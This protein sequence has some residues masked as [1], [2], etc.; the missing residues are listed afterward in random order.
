[1]GKAVVSKDFIEHS[2]KNVLD[3][4]GLSAK[5]LAVIKQEYLDKIDLQ[6]AAKRQQASSNIANLYDQSKIIIDK[7]KE[8]A[9]NEEISL[10]EKEQPEAT[11]E[12]KQRY[13]D[14]VDQLR[15]ILLSH[16]IALENKGYDKEYIASVET[17]LHSLVDLA[18]T[19]T[20]SAENIKEIFPSYS[21]IQTQV[22]SNVIN[23][24]YIL[25]ENK[26]SQVEAPIN[27]IETV[28]QATVTAQANISSVVAPDMDPDAISADE[29]NLLSDFKL[30]PALKAEGFDENQMK[31][32]KKVIFDFN[33]SLTD[34]LGRKPSFKEMV[35]HFIKFTDKVQTEK[36]FDAYR[37]G[38]EANGFEATNYNEVFNEIFE[39]SRNAA[40]A[41]NAFIESLYSTG[42]SVATTEEEVIQSSEK[43]LQEVQSSQATVTDFTEENVPIKTEN[44]NRIS[45]PALRLGFNAIKYDEVEVLDAQGHGTNTFKR[46]A[47]IT[48]TLNEENPLIDYKELLDPDKNNAG[49]V[50]NV[51][52]APENM[53]PEIMISVGRDAH[54][55][56]ILKSFEQIF[57][58]KLAT[59]P[60]F[61]GSAEFIE[62]V[63]MFAYNS[64]GVAVAYIHEAG[65]YNEWNVKDPTSATG[66]V[67]PRNINLAHKEAIEDAKVKA[68]NFREAVHGGLSQVTIKEKA[69]G[70]FYSI[71][72]RK[73]DAG[74]KIPLYTI[75]EANPQSEFAIQGKQNILEQG[76]DKPFENDKRV[77]IN[78]KEIAEKKQGVTWHLRRIGTNPEGQE[79]WRAF[80]V[81]RYPNE[82]ELETVR[83]A[84][85][86]YSLFD[87]KETLQGAKKAKV[88][89][90]V[91]AKFLPTQYS[92]TED[93]AR[94]I[95]KEIKT[96][97]GYNLMEFED[98]M[99]YFNLF[100]QPRTG[101]TPAEFG[102]TL[103]TGEL[104]GFA[105]HTLRDGL[106]K[107]P[108]I[109]MIKNGEVV[110]TN[111]RYTDYLKGTLKTDVK[112]FNIG[113]SDKPVY[114]TSIQPKIVFEY[115]TGQQ[116]NTP[117]KEIAKA[118]QVAEE[119]KQEV[120]STQSTKELLELANGLI[121]ELGFSFEDVQAMPV[122]M[123]GVDHLKNILNLTPGLSIEQEY[124]LLNFTVQY[125][126]NLIDSKFK[127][128]INKALLMKE[129][130]SSYSDIVG[131]SVDKV[132]AVLT[133][134]ESAP[135][136]EDVAKAIGN[137]KAILRVFNNL[138]K[139][140]NAENIKSTL[141]ISG[142]AYNGQIGIVEKA[143]QEAAELADIQEGEVKL[144]EEEE[145]DLSLSEKSFDDAA[146]MTENFKTKTTFRQKRFMSGVSKVDTKGDAIKGFLGLPQY[147]D[148]NE[149]YD[150]IYSLL[151]SGVYIESDYETMKARLLQM[152]DA[153]PWVKE[154]VD[155][156]DNADTQLRKGLVLNYRKHAI[157]MKFMM[158]DNRGTGS[159]L[160]V[161][162]TNAN[163]I[164]RVIRGEWMNNF[165]TSPLVLVDN[166]QYTI[167]RDVA[168]ALLDEFNSW[169]TEGHLQSD[170]TVRTWLS[171]FGIELTDG[172]WN[173]LKEVGMMNNGKY[174]PYSQLF[175]SPNTP[176]GFLG[177]YLNRV[178]NPNNVDYIKDLRFEENEK[179]HPFKDM[180]GVLKALSKGESR[181]TSKILSKSFRDAQKS[182]TGITNPTYITNRV[183][184]LIRS[185]L[186]EEKEFINQL[187][188]L[189]ISH[190]SVMLELMKE[191]PD[192]AKKLELNHEENLTDYILNI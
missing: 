174:I 169:G 105:Q 53:W 94:E 192:F 166:G 73:D 39:P 62:I 150:A 24:Y 167:N 151:G 142:E 4:Y 152:K 113:T 131:P 108:T 67:N 56:P 60:D 11:E 143:L 25:P 157:S 37:V 2:F 34:E 127:G 148:Y 75:E 118:K 123:N 145:D 30:M 107:N 15:E 188:S 74:N 22:L 71:A 41:A 80:G 153:H 72:N 97:T 182:I 9:Q 12:E 81:V 63:P 191:Y 122:E 187:S 124:Q 85:S 172:Y 160:Q 104:S 27:N 1:M 45:S 23:D 59:N 147:M 168:K 119:V 46:V 137:Y 109:P 31:G 110:S 36:F 93:K 158:Y 3:T 68:T 161:Y 38:W 117:A 186:T 116:E 86:A 112:S 159:R 6:E 5:E 96:L 175:S 139:N 52:M 29:D 82:E 66:I 141:E 7:Q 101:N 163:E 178:A 35:Y 57:N 170:A 149:V 103:Y 134:L 171:N 61:K 135:Q 84:W 155:K 180:Q 177:I 76:V 128:K 54:S 33:S 181:F 102:R 164:T 19:Q 190:K 44:E 69:E 121:N 185:G 79:T 173:E 28:A 26:N 99:A 106:S 176:M 50:L 21:D 156:Y 40:I 49:S 183:D 115:E 43:Q 91:R 20:L 98:A 47:V 17:N 144:E 90:E 78:K 65:W 51:G 162:D 8:T 14:N 126:N 48:D 88:I 13:E 120:V 179:A 83:W 125:I 55:K 95:I 154:L 77:I 146:S 114:V 111:K 64:Q 42:V 87:H 133:K 140:W 136:S 130:S 138:E 184:D 58:E 189:S 70:A 18:E 10:F 129:L 92:L 32:L 132:K 100:I 165:I 89:Q 16:P